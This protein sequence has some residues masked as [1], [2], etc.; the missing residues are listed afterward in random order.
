MER[1]EYY[2]IAYLCLYDY[3][4]ATL[5]TGP[6]ALPLMWGYFQRMSTSKEVSA[7]NPTYGIPARVEGCI[8]CRVYV[9]TVRK[10]RKNPWEAREK[11]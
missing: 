1:A 5:E 9:Q 11:N 8:N 10:S 6:L 7:K 4:D 3:K 2:L